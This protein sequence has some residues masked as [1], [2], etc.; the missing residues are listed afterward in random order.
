[1]DTAAGQRLVERAKGY[2]REQ[3]RK[4][5]GAQAVAGGTDSASQMAK[6]AGNKMV[7]DTLGN[8]AAMD[9]Q[10]KAQADAMHQQNRENFARMDMDRYQ[11]NAQNIANAA[12]NASNA[13]FLAG[14]TLDSMEK[15]DL[16]G[17]YNLGRSTKVLDDG[18]VG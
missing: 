17:S 13:A 10:R 2:A 3:W 8:V 16:T 18:G 1:M 4:A 9:T 5:A 14:A 7:G 12:Q 11:R 15:P 6:D